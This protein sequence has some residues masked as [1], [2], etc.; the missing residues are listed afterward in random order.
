MCRRLL[1]EDTTDFCQLLLEGA[2]EEGRG[3]NDCPRPRL[4]SAV[5]QC[6]CSLPYHQRGPQGGDLYC[7]LHWDN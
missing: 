5:C 7:S 3:H 6:S 1:L 2:L 4:T